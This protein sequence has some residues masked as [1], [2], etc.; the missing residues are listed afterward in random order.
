MRVN[1]PRKSAEEKESAKFHNIHP[2][3]K[4][5]DLMRWLCRL[6]TPKGGIILDPYMGSG[7]TGKAAI[8]EDFK[9]IG[10]E[11]DPEY[12]NIAKERIKFFVKQKENINV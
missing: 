12:Y 7:S 2:T 5:T 6:L 4:P 10:I 1:A 11:L 8:L 3:V 9:F